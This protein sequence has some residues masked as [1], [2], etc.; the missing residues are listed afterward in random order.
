MCVCVCVCGV[1]VCVC[2]RLSR[3][4]VITIT[5]SQAM[6]S[7]VMLIPHFITMGGFVDLLLSTF[8]LNGE[9]AVI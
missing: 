1:C 2:V 5:F 8:C 7:F 6:I 3:S 9:T 4:V